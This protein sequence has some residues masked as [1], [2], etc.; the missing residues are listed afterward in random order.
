MARAGNDD[1]ATP[2][3]GAAAVQL[4]HPLTAQFQTP[5]LPA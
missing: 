3:A 5:M 4:P 2:F 1:V